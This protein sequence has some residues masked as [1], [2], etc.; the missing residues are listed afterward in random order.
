MD[1]MG[2]CAQEVLV[3]AAVR[4]VLERR[5]SDLT[6][7]AYL[8]LDDGQTRP[9]PLLAAAR[10]VVRASV[11]ASEGVTA[12]PWPVPSRPG[13]TSVPAPPEHVPAPPEHVPAPAEHV[14]ATGE[15]YAY[16]RRRLV[17]RLLHDLRAPSRLRFRFRRAPRPVQTGPTRAALRVLSPHER[18]VYVLARVEG[19]PVAV[20]ADV[21]DDHLLVTPGDVERALAEVDAATGLDAGDQSTELHSFDPALVRLTLPPSP[22][23]RGRVV[24]VASSV[25]LLAAGTAA[26]AISRQAHRPGDPA[27]VSIGRWRHEHS[28]DL[29]VWPTQG[30][31]KQDLALLR[32]A[33]ESWLRNR[34]DPP[35]GG[36]VVLYAGEIGD[37][38][39][40]IMR[41]TPGNR[42]DYLVAQYVERPLSRGVESVRELRIDS[43]GLILIDALSNRYLVPPWYGDLRVSPLNRPSPEWRKLAIRGGVSDPL[44][45]SWF[46][47]RCQFYVAFQIRDRRTP[48]RT[49]TLLA[50]HVSSA[51]TPAVSFRVPSRG[52][53]DDTTLDSQ[54]RWDAART[55]A[56]SDG[57]SLL[58]SPDLRVGEL[59][60]GTL[61]DH[62]G[63]ARILT[64]ER[65]GDSAEQGGGAVLV[66]EQGHT[67]AYGSS[68][69][70]HVLD[71]DEL[72]A[73]VWWPSRS[74][75][76]HLVV[77]AAPR[78]PRFY[79]LGELGR[80][81]PRGRSIILRG[82]RTA[83]DIDRRPI[84]QAVVYEPDGDRSVITP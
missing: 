15:T 3:H 33:R 83:P 55:L 41:D 1:L 53:S 18:L 25:V 28:P 38:T 5:H 24:A 16:L 65:S 10:A 42:S 23:P 13:E 6:R 84:V 80:R 47:V 43:H 48:D 82:P 36:M 61:P 46:D 79:V 76:W 21:L 30:S 11:R 20:V 59:W 27:L 63:R 78:V 17:A 52:S 34:Q 64:I 50:S 45:W 66:D 77:A 51:A 72:A 60:R 58:D 62:G 2:L 75:R 19:M 57:T 56:C 4:E 37:A 68:N 44:P 54:A 49:I 67:L 69:S 26:Y 12:D 14:P 71:A 9:G 7:L 40:V 32:R 22:S 39:T 31:R 70:D 35:V 73:A 74:G 81:E 8:V 29:T